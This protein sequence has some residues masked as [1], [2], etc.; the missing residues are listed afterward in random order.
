MVRLT[1]T[2]TFEEFKL[3][4]MGLWDGRTNPGT[5][6]DILNGFGIDNVRW[7]SL[8]EIKVSRGLEEFIELALEHG[9]PAQKSEISWELYRLNPN[10]QP[11]REDTRTIVYK[12]SDGGLLIVLISALD[13]INLPYLQKHYTSDRKL[14]QA[15]AFSLGDLGMAANGLHGFPP[16]DCEKRWQIVFDINS[17]PFWHPI[18]LHGSNTQVGDLHV[19]KEV[20]LGLMGNRFP[21][22]VVEDAVRR[23]M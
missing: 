22:R 6:S 18:Y 3:K 7:D 16:L 9:T 11:R 14:E 20:Y 10:K 19:P 15:S 23:D 17:Q 5:V 21:G 8:G 2:K 13:K 12:K 1:E 4:G